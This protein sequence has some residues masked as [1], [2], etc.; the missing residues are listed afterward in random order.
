M[1]LNFYRRPLKIWR[2]KTQN[3]DKLQQKTVN[4]KYVTPKRLHISTNVIYGLK[5]GTKFGGNQGETE[6][7]GGRRSTLSG[8]RTADNCH[9]SSCLS[10]GLVHTVSVLCLETETC[11]NRS[12]HLST[13][14]MHK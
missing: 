5:D 7:T 4:R 9:P 13:D 10:L 2:G 1:L 14:M 11:R 6:T 8:S 12:R 3:F